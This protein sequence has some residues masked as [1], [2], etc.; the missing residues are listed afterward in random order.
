MKT[1]SIQYSTL[2]DSPGDD[3][4]SSKLYRPQPKKWRYI[5]WVFLVLAICGMIIECIFFAFNFWWAD[6]Y[7]ICEILMIVLNCSFLLLKPES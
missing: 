2:V 7:I 5:N 4:S 1:N 3:Q 6:S